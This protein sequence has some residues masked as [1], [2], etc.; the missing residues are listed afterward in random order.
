MKKKGVHSCSATVVLCGIAVNL[1]PGSAVMVSSLR[2]VPHRLITTAPDSEWPCRA[3]HGLHTLSSS[4]I[5]C[6]SDL[7]FVR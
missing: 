5:L 3:R 1:L 2:A 4:L 6:F 7:C